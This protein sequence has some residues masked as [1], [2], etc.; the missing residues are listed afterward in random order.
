MDVRVEEEGERLVCMWGGGGRDELYV[1]ACAHA[2]EIRTFGSECLSEIGQGS[3]CPS[4]NLNNTLVVS[5]LQ[6][7]VCGCGCEWGVRGGGRKG[8]SV[9]V[10]IHVTPHCEGSARTEERTGNAFEMSNPAT[11]RSTPEG[12]ST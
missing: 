6:D 5:S 2:R 10:A 7:R 11:P 4:A 9:G 1:R 3:T 12:Q 8:K